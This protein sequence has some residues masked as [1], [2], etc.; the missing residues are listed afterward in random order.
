MPFI[1][2]S[3]IISLQQ[4][5]GAAIG[6]DAYLASFGANTNYGSHPDFASFGWTC[7]GSPCIG[8]CLLKFDLSSIPAG[9]VIVDAKL[10]LF[11]NPGTP[12]TNGIPMQG[13]NASY[14][15]R[16]TSPWNENSVTYNN[17]PSY[18]TTNGV[19]L[20]QSSAGYQNY[21][22]VNVTTL[23]SDMLTSP[24]MNNGFII[25]LINENPYSVMAFSASDG[26][27]P[28]LW[29]ELIVQYQAAG[30]TQDSCVVFLST[31]PFS[32]DA[33]LASVAPTSNY[34]AHPEFSGFSWT[35]GGSPCYGRGLL[36]FDFSPI[37]PGATIV[38]A[39][40]DLYANPAPVNGAGLAMQGANSSIIQR[41]V[42]PWTEN[43][44]AWNTQPNTISQNSIV[45]PQSS[46]SFQNYLGVNV[47]NLVVDMLNN[48]QTSYGFQL[49]LIN[50]VGYTSMTFASS[51]YSNQSL[52][53]KLRICYQVP[54]GV[55]EN[56]QS[57][58]YL[59]SVFPNPLIG[60]QLQLLLNPGSSSRIQ[61]E[62]VDLQGRIIQQWDK[63]VISRT[64][65]KIDLAINRKDLSEGIYL[66]KINLIDR[67]LVKKVVVAK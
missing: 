38:S 39:T 52:A 5:P 56:N 6:E 43:G 29:P 65:Q 30:T 54:T 64:E 18:S 17:Y 48:P 44:V 47:K 26:T 13:N 33:Y 25:K 61:I 14:L 55:G 49:K 53:P 41:V 8:R 27:D 67:V 2:L 31:D 63:Q 24:N 16:V 11:A 66:L 50:E 45:L 20:A 59:L 58:P 36:N 34:G 9:A 28:L 57:R 51:D 12:N 60:D 40:L 21:L 46:S 35:C 1:A 37:P 42:T 23:I 62:F 32:S 15:Y 22:N 7:G 4:K 10:N 3:Q 19:Y